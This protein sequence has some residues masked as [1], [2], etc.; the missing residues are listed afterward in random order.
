MAKGSCPTR[1]EKVTGE[2]LELQEGKNILKIGKNRGKYNKLSF[3]W[4]FKSYL[5]IEIKPTDVVLKL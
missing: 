5:M 3:S 2:G 1:K 4:G